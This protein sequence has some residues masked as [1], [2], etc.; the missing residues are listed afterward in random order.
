[1]TERT[2]L[3]Y[4]SDAEFGTCSIEDISNY[5]NDGWVP[6]ERMERQGPCKDQYGQDVYVTDEHGC[7]HVKTAAQ[8]FFLIARHR[9]FAHDEAEIRASKAENK[10]WN[11][12]REARDASAKL[13]EAEA[14]AEKLQA[15]V[16]R[17]KS[18]E[19]NNYDARKQAEQKARSLELEVGKLNGKLGRLRDE[20]GRKQMDA[21]L[22][23]L[24]DQS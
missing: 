19:V 23:A 9:D 10:V 16:T 18:A 5:S 14:K 6:V 13:K 17:L 4:G 24:A 3:E 1:M 11:A 7:R 21:I 20:L 12:E 8:P 2:K 22:G 15:E